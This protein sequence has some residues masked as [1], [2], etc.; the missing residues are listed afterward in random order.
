MRFNANF[1]PALSEIFNVLFEIA[2]NYRTDSFSCQSPICNDGNTFIF[3][4]RDESNY[5]IE[6]SLDDFADLDIN[7]SYASLQN[8][9]S[10][11]D[12]IKEHKKSNG[13]K[14]AALEAF[15]VHAEHDNIIAK[16][17]YGYYLDKEEKL[18]N[19]KEREQRLQKAAALFKETADDGSSDGQ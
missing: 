18:L 13:N 7:D 5:L 15:R 6:E 14:K 8:V 19:S 4:R 16:Y 1:R 12:A 2:E 9:M 10:I 11:Q 3:P 17:W